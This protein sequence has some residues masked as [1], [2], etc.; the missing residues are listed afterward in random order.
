[1]TDTRRLPTLSFATRLLVIL[2][3]GYQTSCFKLPTHLAV[4]L[5]TAALTR[6]LDKI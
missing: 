4:R 2:L 6:L 5:P 3:F 1:M